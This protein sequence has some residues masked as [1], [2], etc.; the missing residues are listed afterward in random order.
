VEK[1]QLPCG[2]CAIKAKPAGQ[3][4]STLLSTGPASMRQTLTDGSS[5]SLAARTQPAEPPP[6][7]M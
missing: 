3:W 4:M 1:R 7:M 6:T 5:L 2:I